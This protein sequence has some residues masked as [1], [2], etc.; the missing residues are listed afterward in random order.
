MSSTTTVVVG[1]RGFWAL[2]DAFAVWLAYLVESIGDATASLAEQ[3][4]THWKVATG[5]P[6]FG[7]TVKGLDAESRTQLKAAAIRARDVAAAMGDVPESRLREWSL[8]EGLTVSD[9]FS[10]S[11]DAVPVSRILE[12][13]DGFV[14]L[15]DGSF[16]DDPVEG[17]WFLGTGDGW[18]VM[19]YN[20][21]PL[22][23]DTPR[24]RVDR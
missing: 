13:A 8:A 14:D 3:R 15:M 1:D 21:R 6:D 24:F 4:D 18:R 20:D 5:V 12:V 23:P 22:S 11:G 16:P 17:A 2:D 19:P 9:G 10:R 7:M